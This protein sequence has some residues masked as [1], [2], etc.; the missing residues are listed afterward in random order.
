MNDSNGVPQS[1]HHIKANI[2]WEAFKE[3]PGSSNPPDMLFDLEQL[4]QRLDVLDSLSD[5]F[6]HEEIAAVVANLPSDISPGLD[7]F[8]VDFV[9]SVSLLLSR[10]LQNLCRFACRISM[11]SEFEWVT[12]NFASKG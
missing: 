10:T 11:T 7:G 8:N 12:H 1:N 4:L 5:P 9:K 3:S 2:L 6:T